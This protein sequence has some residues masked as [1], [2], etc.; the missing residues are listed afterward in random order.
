MSFNAVLFKRPFTRFNKF[1]NG[2]FKRIYYYAGYV[3]ITL[4]LFGLLRK[5]FYSE[6][7]EQKMSNAYVKNEFDT[8]LYKIDNI[9]LLLKFLASVEEDDESAK[10]LF[11]KVKPLYEESIQK[12]QA[13]F[14]TINKENQAQIEKYMNKFDNETKVKLTNLVDA[15][16]PSTSSSIVESDVEKQ[17]ATNEEKETVKQLINASAVAPHDWKVG[18]LLEARDRSK[19][20]Y[21]WYLSKIIEIKGPKCKIHFRNWN[22]RFDKWYYMNSPDLRPWHN[23]TE[24]EKNSKFKV[25]DKVLAKNPDEEQYLPCRIDQMKTDNETLYYQVL[26]YEMDFLKFLVKC[27]DVKELND[28]SIENDSDDQE[29]SI[30]PIESESRNDLKKLPTNQ[31]INSL[32]KSSRTS[33]SSSSPSSSSSNVKVATLKRKRSEI[34]EDDVDLSIEA[35]GTKLNDVIIYNFLI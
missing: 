4:I 29:I 20:G 16:L 11:K 23:P 14:E 2:L 35:L 12:L 19:N 17:A 1:I 30:P 24:L 15:T 13:F 9:R 22:S 34:E 10:K 21:D 32:V 28:T 33:V 8:S 31:R 27:D 5:K 6:T 7:I 3:T 26:F 18:S 25:G